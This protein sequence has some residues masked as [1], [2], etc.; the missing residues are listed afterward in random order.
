MLITESREFGRSSWTFSARTLSDTWH[1]CGDRFECVCLSFQSTKLFLI[2]VRVWGKVLHTHCDHLDRWVV[3]LAR[4][5]SAPNLRVKP[6]NTLV[7]IFNNL[8]TEY[9][10]KRSPQP[11]QWIQS[12]CPNFRSHIS[13][14]CPPKLP[15]HACSNGVNYINFASMFVTF[16]G[17]I[18]KQ[19]R[20]MTLVDLIVCIST[21]FWY[22]FGV[23]LD[24]VA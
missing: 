17:I 18:L 16:C 6:V 15:K 10:S 11:I 1:D 8:Q 3:K 22:T 19:Y 20:T 23:V 13:L 4:L 9:A 2:C 24:S 12:N 14:I 7:Q 5:R 21:N